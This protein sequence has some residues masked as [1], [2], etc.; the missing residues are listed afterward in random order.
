MTRIWT[1]ESVHIHDIKTKI[2]QYIL[3]AIQKNA[4]T[5]PINHCLKKKKKKISSKKRD[6]S[7]E[8]GW[9]EEGKKWLITSN[10]L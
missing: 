5:H 1:G 10:S 6:F 2:I 4:T 8:K 3:S 7:F 9:E